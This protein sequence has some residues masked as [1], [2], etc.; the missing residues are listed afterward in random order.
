MSKIGPVDHLPR[1]ALPWRTEADFTE[2]GKP[3]ADL[4]VERV[5]TVDQLQARIR[6]V[7]KTRAAFTACMTC[8]GTAERW[9][10]QSALETVVRELQGMEWAS[11]PRTDAERA[12]AHSKWFRK[13]RLLAELQAITALVA[14]HRDEFDGYLVGL[15][16]TTSLADARRRRRAR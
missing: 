5:I 15:A 13:Q 12:D 8:W 7:G 4:P 11:P 9:R 6:D 1:Q 2:C 10:R 16:E 14:A 3:L